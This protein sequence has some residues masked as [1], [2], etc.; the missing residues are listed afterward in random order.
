[1]LRRELDHFP[2]LTELVEAGFDL[3]ETFSV[4]EI[5]LGENLGFLDRSGID[6]RIGLDWLNQH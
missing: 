3:E 6:I 5:R 4:S 2:P 1:M